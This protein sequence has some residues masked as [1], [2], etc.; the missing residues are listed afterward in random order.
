ML[1]FF[2]LRPSFLICYTYFTSAPSVGLYLLCFY[3]TNIIMLCSA[4]PT[5]LVSSAELTQDEALNVTVTSV[6]DD[7]C[8]T[9]WNICRILSQTQST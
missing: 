8:G 1:R 2:P 7:T 3:N 6:Q 9:S 5:R 4:H